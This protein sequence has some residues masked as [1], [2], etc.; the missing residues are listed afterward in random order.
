MRYWVYQDARVQG[1]FS[2]EDLASVQGLDQ[3]SLVCQADSSGGAKEG[4]WTAM[5]DLS[6]LADLYAV[7]SG[8]SLAPATDVP[9]EI[10]SQF[11][12]ES[13][14]VLD[15][16]GYPEA[17]VSGVFEDPT[18]FDVHAG[19]GGAFGSDVAPNPES[20][21]TAELESRLCEL[22]DQIQEYEKKTNDIL[23][24]LGGKDKTIETLKE[25]LEAFES[26]AEIPAKADAAASADV[27]VPPPSS[28]EPD[29]P[30]LESSPAESEPLVQA[31]GRAPMESEDAAPA[32]VPEP[33]SETPAP[34][35]D[36][37]PPA[38]EEVPLESAPPSENADADSELEAPALEEI[39]S[40]PEPDGLPQTESLK[41]TSSMPEGEEF[42]PPMP[43]EVSAD[44]PLE[45]PPLEAP[46]ADAPL[47]PPPLEA[48]A[49]D[50]PLEPPPLEA[51]AADAPLEPPPLEAPAADVSLEPPPAVPAQPGAV[52]SEAPP[53]GQPKTMVFGQPGTPVPVEL[54]GASEAPGQ[55]PVQIPATAAGPVPTEVP[56][57]DVPPML[58]GQA[59]TPMPIPLGGAATPM[60]GE[61]TP[62]PAMGQPDIPQTVLQGMG[63]GGTT[64]P[65]PGT[66]TPAGS[67][68]FEE[69]MGKPATVTPQLTPASP[70]VAKTGIVKPPAGGPPSETG[71]A[72]AAESKFKKFQ[73]KKFLIGLGLAGVIL[74]VLLVLFFQNP[75]D[76]QQMVEMS[77]EQ[78]AAGDVNAGNPQN[79]FGGGQGQGEAPPTQGSA[80]G[81]PPRQ[82]VGQPQQ[83]GGQVPP[84]GGGFPSQQPSGGFAQQQQ[85][86]GGF[87]PQQ[88]QEQFSQPSAAP[89]S[90]G[91]RDFIQDDQIQ[92]ME[93]VKNYTLSGAKGTVDGWLA[94]SFPPPKMP[95]WSAGGVSKDVWLV[96]YLV[97]NGPRSKTPDITYSFE[98]NLRNQSLKA[99]NSATKSL[100][101]GSEGLNKKSSFE[102]PSKQPQALP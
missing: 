69:L 57:G 102:P 50:A 14:G 72:P 70:G 24:A 5:S 52:Q 101:A 76:V 32:D 98:V 64:T 59:P 84:Q 45:P 47:E 87:P 27:D 7:E 55:T 22:Q 53:L 56:G 28:I 75:K 92:A 83:Q 21:R 63:V 6:E 89:P 65:I 30:I 41:A 18:M 8:V 91:G 38:V 25:R 61:T 42:V 99:R 37:V 19:L 80:G 4:D 13:E 94:Y 97:F 26:G 3:D 51:P 96:E 40:E 58:P 39:A 93:F 79:T 31:E 77:P 48:P 10:F 66:P 11:R 60:P 90:S 35:D 29:E 71:G 15:R 67:Q 68:S 73:S 86:G 44:A 78:P 36:F 95:Q 2:K 54:G 82:P 100:L 74:I 20:G 1:P 34:I 23:D 9:N 46:A 43:S 81:F 17:W 12:K 88:P 33:I 85:G 62:M 16:I 49:A